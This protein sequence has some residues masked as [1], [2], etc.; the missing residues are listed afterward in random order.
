MKKAIIGSLLLV[1][2]LVGGTSTADTAVPVAE[3]EVAE[4]FNRLVSALNAKDASAWASFYSTDGFQ[5]AIAG[6]RQYATRA[7]WVQTITG[8]FAQRASQQVA[9]LN[10]KV[11]ALSTDLAL[12]TSREKSVIRMK[13]GKEIRTAHAFTMLWKREPAGWKVIHSHESW[14]DEP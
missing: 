1:G 3:N 7:E 9:P 10:V 11:T 14:M 5:S 4:Q 13:D 6:S 8:Y 2:L 12:L